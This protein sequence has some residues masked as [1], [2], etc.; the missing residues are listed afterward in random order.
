MDTVALWRKANERI[1]YE[2]T[3][4]RE[5]EAALRQFLERLNK[6]FIPIVITDFQDEMKI[7]KA[8]K[9]KAYIFGRFKPRDWLRAAEEQCRA[10]RKIVN[11]MN[12]RSRWDPCEAGRIRL[13]KLVSGFFSPLLGIHRLYHL[14]D[15]DPPNSLW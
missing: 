11:D 8:L 10:D 3:L 6:H 1:A 12:L 13:N 7:L 9:E 5:M 15:L 4:P 14:A 2:G